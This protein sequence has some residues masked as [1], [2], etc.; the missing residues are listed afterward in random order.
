MTPFVVP[1]VAVIEIA[2]L[3]RGVLWVAIMG[4]LT[5]Y[6]HPLT[7]KEFSQQVVD[8]AFITGWHVHRTWTS[9]HS[10]AG[11]PDL[12][13][14]RPPR[15]IIA[16]LKAEGKKLTPDQADWL[17]CLRRVPGI[18]V[19]CWWPSY[20]EIIVATLKRKES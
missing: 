8:L 4:H 6:T 17:E 10:P 3:L 9:I 14:C 19:A 15:L 16:E 13:L 1:L 18:E 20:W 12:V 11:W 5:N 7:E 2:Q